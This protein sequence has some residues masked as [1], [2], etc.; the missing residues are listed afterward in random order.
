MNLNDI[1]HIKLLKLAEEITSQNDK[2]NERIDKI[3]ERIDKINNNIY[4]VNVKLNYTVKL[5][6]KLEH[7]II[8]KKHRV[9]R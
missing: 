2:I 4:D 3:N 5:L 6:D 9:N 1:N 7:K 8:I